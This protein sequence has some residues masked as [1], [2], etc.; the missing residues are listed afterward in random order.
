MR[1]GICALA[2]LLLAGCGL[3]S[4]G[5]AG[6]RGLVRF[7]L[8]LDYAASTDFSSPVAVDRTVFVALQHPKEGLLDD[9][10]FTELTLRVEGP[11][12]D[13]VES[14]FPLGFAQ[15]GVV[16]G[17]EGRYRLLA[18]QA[19]G[20]ILDSTELVAEPIDRIDVDKTVRV[21][22]SFDD[23][24]DR[25][26]S[27]QEMSLDNVVLHANQ[28]VE[29]FLVPRSKND[30]P[31]LGLLALTA[32]GPGSVQLD[33]PLI[34]QGRTANALVVTPK[35]EMADT[36]SLKIGDAESSEAIEVT[37]PATNDEKVLDCSS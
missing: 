36:L 21:T 37:L 26:T 20:E 8:V 28:T 35:A 15:Y 17:E 4:D 2:A 11:D 18:L 3:V 23:G 34:G 13:D 19:N 22:T 27:L 30:E 33:A 1:A 12:G 10:T 6:E 25:C 31:M 5:G 29:M 24:M 32:E 7:S 9:E 16:L 14:V